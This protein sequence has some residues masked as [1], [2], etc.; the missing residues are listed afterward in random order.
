LEPDQRRFPVPRDRERRAAHAAALHGAKSTS[1]AS[2]SSEAQNKNPAGASTVC[3]PCRDDGEHAR[4]PEKLYA[5]SVRSR[6]TF[7][8][9]EVSH[10]RSHVFASPGVLTGTELE[11]GQF[12]EPLRPIASLPL[13][14]PPRKPAILNQLANDGSELKELHQIG[15]FSEID[16]STK[17]RCAVAI[18]RCIR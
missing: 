2:T 16:R 1:V 17:S 13:R 14:S 8:D 12:I 15:R 7:R 4:Q 9:G 18:A 6:P 3:H 10:L 5:A 11:R